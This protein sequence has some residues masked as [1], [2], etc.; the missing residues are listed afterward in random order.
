M[1]VT[2]SEDD[3]TTLLIHSPKNTWKGKT[4]GPDTVGAVQA[5]WT[6]QDDLNR[7]P[8]MEEAV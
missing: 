7:E 2:N 1:L 6:S 4:T 5:D 3:L 8:G